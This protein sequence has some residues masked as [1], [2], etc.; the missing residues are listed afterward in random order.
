MYIRSAPIVMLAVAFVLCSCPNTKNVL[1]SLGVS[2]S[3]AAAYMDFM[4]HK[5][6]AFKG[7]TADKYIVIGEPL[8]WMIGAA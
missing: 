3:V 4:V 7:H 8:T 5:H 2:F 1:N 6:L